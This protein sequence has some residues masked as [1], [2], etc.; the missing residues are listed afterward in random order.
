MVIAQL[1]LDKCRF[2]SCD[3]SL[4]YYLKIFV[5]RLGDKILIVSDTDW[6]TTGGVK[7]I[8]CMTV[9]EFIFYCLINCILFRCFTIVSLIFKVIF[10]STFCIFLYYS[11]NFWILN[12]NI[13]GKLGKLWT[14]SK[15]IFKL[16]VAKEKLLYCVMTRLCSVL[17]K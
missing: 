16:W 17:V 15:N 1:R 11:P 14:T 7:R 6:P 12:F 2:D 13:L 4:S 9:I 5:S 8:E 3:A 10:C